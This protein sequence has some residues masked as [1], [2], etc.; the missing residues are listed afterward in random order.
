MEPLLKCDHLAVG[1]DGIA[2]SVP[3]SFSVYN[4]DYLCVLGVNGNGKTTF[5]NTILGITPKISGIITYEKGLT[6]RDIGY[7]PQQ[8][9]EKLG[10]P[11]TVEDIVMQGCFSRIGRKPLFTAKYKKTARKSMERLG[12]TELS[13]RPYRDLSGGQQQR[14]LIARAF[15]ATEKLMVLDEPVNGLDPGLTMGIYRFLRDIN[16]EGMTIIMST[17]DLNAAVTYASHIL[18]IS[19]EPFFGTVEEFLESPYSRDF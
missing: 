17:N 18:V 1:H 5:L 19:E 6:T 9:D 11:S 3:M 12:I 14:V 16:E 13:D 7:L 4:G 15:C 2:L 8:T 10:F